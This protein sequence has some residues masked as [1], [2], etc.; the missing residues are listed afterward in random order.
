MHGWK[1]RL[2]F[3]FCTFVGIVKF[4]GSSWNDGI[5]EWSQWDAWSRL[6]GYVSLWIFIFKTKIS[7]VRSVGHES[8]PAGSIKAWKPSRKMFFSTHTVSLFLPN[9]LVLDIFY[10]FLIKHLYDDIWAGWGWGRKRGCCSCRRRLKD[11]GI[12]LK[13]SKGSLLLAPNTTKW[14]HSLHFHVEL[15]TAPPKA[16]CTIGRWNIHCAYNWFFLLI[17][18]LPSSNSHKKTWEWTRRFKQTP[19]PPTPPPQKKQTKTSSNLELKR[20]VG[21]K[22]EKR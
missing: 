8:Y 14:W 5:P 3:C 10:L 4:L 17:N 21:K 18:V 9:L 20:N 13:G 2:V 15:S 1:K 16:V 12:T 7:C 6:E 11:S 22:E 19:P